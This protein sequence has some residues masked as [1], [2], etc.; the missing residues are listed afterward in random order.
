MANLKQCTG[1][2]KWLTAEDL[3]S[4]PQLEPL[5]MAFLKGKN[6][7][8]YF[9][10][11]H[12]TPECGTTFLLE[13]DRLKDYID[14]PFPIVNLKDTEDCPLENTGHKS[15]SVCEGDCVDLYD[16]ATCGRECQYAPYRRF[17]QKMIKM[18]QL[19]TG[20]H[21]LIDAVANY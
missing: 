9:H 20:E 16:L 11:L 14:E 12:K 2:K 4:D 21:R 7:R 18:K 19:D 13:A 8:A 6:A 10:F 15:E 1:C 3:T 5:G 17:L